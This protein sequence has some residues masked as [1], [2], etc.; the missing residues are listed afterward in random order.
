MKNIW[1][2][3]AALLAIIFSPIVPAFADCVAIQVE[4]GPREQQPIPPL[5]K[6][7]DPI[8]PRESLSPTTGSAEYH[9]EYRLDADDPATGGLAGQYCDPSGS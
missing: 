7:G 6:W 3:I 2:L 5:D 1:L 8:S 4:T 9:T